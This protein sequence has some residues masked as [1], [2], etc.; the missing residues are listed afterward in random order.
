MAIPGQ[1]ILHSSLHHFISPP[2]ITQG[3]PIF[4][5]KKI[6]GLHTKTAAFFFQMF[7][8][9]FSINTFYYVV[10][11]CYTKIKLIQILFVGRGLFCFHN[12]KSSETFITQN[13]FLEPRH[14][15]A[16]L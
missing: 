4:R 13:F 10:S 5:S 8:F 7:H 9:E 2:W 15:G 1:T 16:C 3:A 14:G 11:N 6:L 12:K